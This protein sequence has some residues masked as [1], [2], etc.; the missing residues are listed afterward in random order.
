M[1]HAIGVVV[2]AAISVLP[3]SASLAQTLPDYRCVIERVETANNDTNAKV[4]YRN[5]FGKEFT[6]ERKTG[7]MAG[8]LKNNYVTVPQ[9]IDFGSRENSFKAVATMRREQ[10]VGAGS[11]AYILTVNEYVESERKPFLFVQNDEAFFGYCTHF[12]L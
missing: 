1:R 6:V 2:F 12:E 9:I 10:G 11:N 5:Y 3:F 7:I 8:A 4:L